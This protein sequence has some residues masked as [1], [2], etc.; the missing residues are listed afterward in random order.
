[1]RMNETLQDRLLE[2]NQLFAAGNCNS[3][4]QLSHHALRQAHGG[5]WQEQM[6]MMQL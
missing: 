2:N 1:M 6:K 3:I 4:E 5:Q